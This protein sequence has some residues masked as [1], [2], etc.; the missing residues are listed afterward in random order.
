MRSWLLAVL[1]T[2]TA[3]TGSA[4]GIEWQTLLEEAVTL[5][6]RGQYARAVAVATKALDLAKTSTPPTPQAEIDSSA[7]LALAYSGNRQP[8][9]AEPLFTRYLDAEKIRLGAETPEYAAVL[10]QVAEAYQRDGQSA[11]SLALVAPS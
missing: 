9:E 4:Q 10:A 3:A 11:K 1:L 7:Q 2:G 8:N 5:N 6:Q